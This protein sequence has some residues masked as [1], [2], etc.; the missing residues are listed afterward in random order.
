MLCLCKIHNWVQVSEVKHISTMASFTFDFPRSIDQSGWYDVMHHNVEQC[1]YFGNTLFDDWAFLKFSKNCLWWKP[2]RNGAIHVVSWKL[3]TWSVRPSFF[4]IS[5]IISSIW[6]NNVTWNWLWI[7]NVWSG[8]MRCYIKTLWI[9]G[10]WLVPSY[11]Y[12]PHNSIKDHLCSSKFHKLNFF[13][14]PISN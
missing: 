1:S 13:L 2:Y 5:G 6:G 12:Y 11:S 4:W 10:L 14:L 9:Y 3:V 8:S 7:S